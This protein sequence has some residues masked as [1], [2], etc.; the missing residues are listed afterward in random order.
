MPI[1]YLGFSKI[2]KYY[3]N[4]NL[5]PKLI[6]SAVGIDMTLFQ[7]GQQ[8]RVINQNISVLNMADALKTQNN[9]MPVIKKAIVFYHGIF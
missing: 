2:H 8:I 1:S 7:F 9:L 3:K 6:V 4:I 5:N